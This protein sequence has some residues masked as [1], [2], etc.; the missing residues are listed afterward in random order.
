MLG[1]AAE[2]GLALVL[3]EIF[4]DAE[5]RPR[6]RL[7]AAGQ[8][9]D[10]PIAAEHETRGAE[11]VQRVRRHGTQIFHRPRPRFVTGPV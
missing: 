5:Q 11:K 8:L 1:G 3:V 4:E 7:V 2:H 6:H 9:T 10:R